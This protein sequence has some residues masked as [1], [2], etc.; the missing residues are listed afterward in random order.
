[1]R[2]K[3]SMLRTSNLVLPTVHGVLSIVCY[4]LLFVLRIAEYAECGIHNV[5]IVLRA[6]RW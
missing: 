6:V 1:M 2:I 4:L 5:R 3:Y